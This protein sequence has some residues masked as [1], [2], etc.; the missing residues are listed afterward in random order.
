VA[1]ASPA[2][3]Q[4]PVKVDSK[5]YKTV[6]ENER[7]RVLSAT[8]EPNHK[9]VMHDHPDNFVVFMDDGKVRFKLGD[10]TI[11]PEQ[12]IKAGDVITATAGKHA[13]ENLGGAINVFVVEVK[14]GAPKA[15]AAVPG[16]VPPPSGAGLT[17]TPIVSSAHGE[18]V[19]LK[20]DAGFEEP[21]GTTHEYDA[22]VVPMGGTGASLTMSGKTVVMKKGEAYL[23][24]RGTAHAVKA[25]APGE[26]IVVYIKQ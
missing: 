1:I 22:V 13:P 11:T 2:R 10:G 9:G 15:P 21:A 25:T 5:T 4:D 24:P 19:R 23:I 18:A 6:A 16:A 26:S 17:R 3:A 12:A 8:V 14:P 20:S 7:V